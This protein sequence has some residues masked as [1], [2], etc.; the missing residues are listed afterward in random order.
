M[1][2]D[3][4]MGNGMAA[5]DCG[6]PAQVLLRTPGSA[7]GAVRRREESGWDG[8]AREQCARSPECGPRSR[9]GRTV[10]VVAKVDPGAADASKAAKVV[11]VVNSERGKAVGLGTFWGFGVGA[12]VFAFGV[13]YGAGYGVSIGMGSPSANVPYQIPIFGIGPTL[14]ALCGVGIGFGRITG[15]KFTDP[16]IDWEEVVMGTKS[17]GMSRQSKFKA[18]FAPK[19]PRLTRR[20]L[21][22]V[23]HVLHNFV[24]R[25]SPSLGFV[26]RL[27]ASAKRPTLPE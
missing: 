14:G 24:G 7:D 16:A 2:R 15:V 23:A 27:P 17:W 1:G 10:A 3:G 4:G 22:H 26:F 12:G 5:R 18:S 11:Q 25:S 8:Q 21:D 9:S 13:G 6:R 19:L 20:G